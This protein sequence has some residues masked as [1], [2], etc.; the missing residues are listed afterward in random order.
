LQDWSLRPA[1]VLVSGNKSAGCTASKHYQRSV[2]IIHAKH[3]SVPLLLHMCATICK[4]HAP[5]SW[6]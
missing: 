5:K 6:A 4:H 3:R 2:N 1:N